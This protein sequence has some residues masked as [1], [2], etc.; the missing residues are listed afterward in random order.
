MHNFNRLIYQV[1]F[2]LILFTLPLKENYNSF[3]LIVFFLFFTVENKNKLH[4]SLTK[5]TLLFVLPFIY[6]LAQMFNSYEEE[7]FNNLIRHLPILIFPLFSKKYKDYEVDNVKLVKVYTSIATFYCLLLIL[8]SIYRQF[9]YYQA[10]SKINWFYF[11]YH[12]FTSLLD[13]HPTYFGL[14]VCLA[15]ILV[16]EAVFVKK[17]TI[18]LLQLLLFFTLIFLLGSRIILISTILISI[19]FIAVNFSSFSKKVGLGILTILIIFPLIIFNTVPIVKE[20]MVDMTFGLKENFEYAKYGE[21][22]AYNGGLGPRIEIWNCAIQIT[23]GSILFG[24]GYGCT[25]CLLNKCYKDK[26]LDTYA[27]SYYQTHNQYFNDYARGGLVGLL[28]LLAVFFIPLYWSIRN[29]NYTYCYFIIL[30][31]ISSFTENILNRHFGIVFYAMFNSI[32]FYSFKM[33]D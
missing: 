15:Y 29:K 23:K 26:G 1:L 8:Y 31:I 9:E 28:I 16:M 30:I 12:D 22:I 2:G 5:S 10:F 6:L 33:K 20:R 13:I 7:F 4:F 17:S 27:K 11:V 21:D 19:I 32:F 24:N 3:F 25:Q 14:F 18:K